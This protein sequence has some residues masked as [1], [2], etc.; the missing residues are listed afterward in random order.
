MGIIPMLILSCDKNPSDKSICQNCGTK[1]DG[2][3]I[4]NNKTGWLVFDEKYNK[5]AI[6]V[7]YSINPVAYI[8]CNLPSYFQTIEMEATVVFSGTVIGDPFI[9][10]DLSP[11]T[12]YCIK[13]D[14][15]TFQKE[16]PDPDYT[17]I[18][19]L[20]FFDALR[21]IAI[22]HTPDLPNSRDEYVAITSP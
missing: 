12:Y 9:T 3:E 10:T 1:T 19:S 7:P 17:R 5:Y 8:P 22:I 11:I 14:T 20:K 2:I 15:I 13:I 6:E 16:F 21:G 18:L 4:V